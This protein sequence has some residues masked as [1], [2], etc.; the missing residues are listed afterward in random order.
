MEKIK[1]FFTGCKD[2]GGEIEETGNK[3]TCNYE[4]MKIVLNKKTNEVKI[5]EDRKL[6]KWDKLKDIEVEP[7]HTITEN[8]IRKELEESILMAH[9]PLLKDLNKFVEAHKWKVGK[10]GATMVINFESTPPFVVDS[11]DGIINATVPPEPEIAPEFKEKWYIKREL[12]RRA[13]RAR[14]G[15][16]YR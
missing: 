7:L 9:P 16:I 10:K 4:D 3:L 12:A 8:E 14:L 5:Y 1:L 2:T 13:S 15:R 11:I 6:V